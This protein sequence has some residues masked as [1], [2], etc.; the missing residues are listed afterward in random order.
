ML[1][2]LCLGLLACGSGGDGPTQQSTP[3]E[4]SSFIAQPS[5]IRAGGSSTLRWTISGAT[6]LSVS[7][8]IGSVSGANITV[9]PSRTTLY[10]LTASNEAGSVQRQAVLGLLPSE[11]LVEDFESATAPAPWLFSNGAE[12]PGA[13]G[14]LTAGPGFVGKGAHLAYDL[15][16]GGAYVAASR[17]LP[18]PLQAAAVTFQAR[19]PLG[20]HVVLRVIDA[21][22]QTL[23]YRVHRPFNGSDAAAWF[24]PVVDLAAPDLSWGGAADGVVH[25]KLGGLAILA[26]DPLE[27]GAI[28][29][30][31]F[32][33]VMVFDSLLPELDSSS[34]QSLPGSGGTLAERLGVNIHF[35]KDD[36]ALDAAH[37]AGISWVRMDLF[38]QGVE[39]S[40]GRYDFSAYDALLAALE[41]RSMKLLAI[42]DYGNP[43]Y[44]ADGQPPNSPAAIQAFG[45]FAEATARHFPGHGVRY[46]IWNE[47]NLAGFWPPRADAAQYLPVLQEAVNR[48]HTGD[49]QALV[50]TGG[51]SGFD[52]PFLRAELPGAMGADAIG[53]HPYRQ[54][55]GE[56]ASED[57]LLWRSIVGE[58]TAT[59][60]PTWDTEWGYSSTWF[61]D[62]HAATARKRQAVL[63]V[64]ELLT[65]W[66]LGLPMAIYYDLRDDGDDGSNSEHNFGLLAQDGTDK[67]AMTAVRTLSAQAQGRTLAG[68][69][70]LW[71]TGVCALRLDGAQDKV[72]VLWNTGGQAIV[73]VPAQARGLDL[74]G[75]SLTLLPGD[76][77]QFLSLLET[78]GPVYLTL[79]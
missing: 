37:K 2:V 51:L 28:G 3:P 47:P 57:L 40:A 23:Q 15:S 75:N 42:L 46:E 20:I 66:S 12:F 10:T 35:T 50:S 9:S 69:L 45:D 5:V 70:P 7:P 33:D 17:T 34:L 79:P 18:Q 26:A 61:G 1:P 39:T 21:T 13:T 78:D 48:V 16:L 59:N 65:A 76:S 67:L 63:A 38:W 77:G 25:G 72:V 60:P 30:L 62:G 6:D 73:R 27:A 31:D 64:R 36:A 4:I 22:G 44:S 43:L 49:P 14:S 68:L 41:A 32:D 19:A 29:A 55:G 53:V 58:G 71:P 52:F 74:L 8:D 56:T 54:G 11:T 24:R